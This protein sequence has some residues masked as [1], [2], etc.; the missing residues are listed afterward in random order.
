MQSKSKLNTPE[1]TS[2]FE[3]RFQEMTQVT[4]KPNAQMM[5]WLLDKGSLTQKLINHFGDFKV[6]VVFEGWITSYQAKRF[7]RHALKD[8][9]F[10]V[11]KFWFRKVNLICNGHIV[12]RAHTLVPLQTFHNQTKRIGKLHSKSLGQFLFTHKHI[13]RHPITVS[14][15]N[16]IWGRQSIF[17]IRD[18]PLLVTEYFEPDFLS[19]KK[20]N[21]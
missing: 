21:S 6:E 3:N 17:N 10:K 9:A 20:L 12:V 13:K 1:F 5:H 11:Q 15:N 19:S 18:Y 16:Q 8:K 14:E 4:N 2:D 7:F